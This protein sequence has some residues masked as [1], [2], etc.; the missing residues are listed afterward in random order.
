MM[1][2]FK[3]AGELSRNIYVI[4]N[5]YICI[6]KCLYVYASANYAIIGSDNGLSP[7]RPQ[8]INYLNQ[9]C[10]LPRC[11]LDHWEQFSAT[12]EK[13]KKNEFENMEMSLVAVPP[14]H[15]NSLVPGNVPIF[16][17]V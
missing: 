1:T 11:Q 14:A 12:F 5:I 9:C 16:S 13:N 10:H 2:S 17:E 7:V 6:C 8:A 4:Y 3:M 15:I